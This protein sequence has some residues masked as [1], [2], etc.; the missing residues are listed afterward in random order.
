MRFTFTN[1]REVSFDNIAEFS[2]LEE[3]MTLVDIVNDVTKEVHENNFVETPGAFVYELD[4]AVDTR[5]VYRAGVESLNVK[6]FTRN[7]DIQPPPPESGLARGFMA[8]MSRSRAIE[9]L[10]NKPRAI[11][12]VDIPLLVPLENDAFQYQT[13]PEVV[14]MHLLCYQLPDMDY[15][16]SFEKILPTDY[17]LV[18]VF[19]M[20]YNHTIEPVLSRLEEFYS[21]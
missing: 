1:S 12:D 11:F 15:Y 13:K 21:N 3:G 7:P 4:L 14:L 8:Q 17:R 18:E 5:E 20:E 19:Q 10:N 16:Y 9:F 6:I 2:D